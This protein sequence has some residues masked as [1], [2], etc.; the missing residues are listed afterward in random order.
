MS[1]LESKHRQEKHHLN[2]NDQPAV[3]SAPHKHSR[4]GD[5]QI[6]GRHIRHHAVLLLMALIIFL[7]ASCQGGASDSTSSEN[8]Q[9]AGENGEIS[10][11]ET[12][13][14]AAGESPT[15]I[16]TTV[17]LLPATPTP[18]ASPTPTPTPYAGFSDPD[19]V[20]QNFEG[21]SGL[22]TFRGNPTR[23]FHGT[24]PMPINPRV[25]WRFGVGEELCSF[26]TV[27]TETTRWCGTGWTGQPT[28]FDYNERRWVVFGSYKPALHFLDA[29]TGERI[30]ADFDVGDLIKGSATIDPDGY[31]LV[32]FGSRDDYFRIVAF[33]GEAPRELWKLWAYEAPVVQWNNDWDGAALV[34]D[35]YLIE[36]GENSNLH[37]VKLNRGYDAAG[38]VTVAPEIIA[39]EQGWDDELLAAIGD[40]MTSIETSV[41]VYENTVWFA[42]SGGL[43]QGW[44]ISKIKDG[45]RPERV[46]RFWAGDDVDASIVFDDEGFMYVGVEYERA[47]SRAYEVGQIMK[48]DPNKPEAPLVWSRE[49]Q[50]NLPDGVWATPAIH[51]NVVY[52]PTNEGWLFALDRYSGNVIWKKKLPGPVWSSPV[53]VDD[54]LVQADCSGN[55]NA[56]DVSDPNVE[57]DQLW[58]VKLGWCIE[59]TPAV[60]EGQIVV[61]H[62]RGEVV[63]VGD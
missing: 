24:G 28:I 39:I 62:R 8:Q 16:P 47:L 51:K 38:Y 45:G 50:L 27:G 29:T 46:F 53:V 20:G 58:R 60:W 21:A 54:V 31:P 5:L 17:P 10:G 6:S 57:P 23:S 37:I 40:G 43:V 7:G 11:A 41:T 1:T 22:L 3:N 26:S 18:T 56:W 12:I 52:V 4:H 55:L 9:L 49:L 33:D 35:D 13:S 63:S 19:R 15:A 36:G 14:D 59:S 2:Q 48:L 61:G 34:L 42:N 32:Y 30:L 25:Q 44:D